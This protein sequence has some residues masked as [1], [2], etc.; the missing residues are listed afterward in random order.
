[1]KIQDLLKQAKP[2][3]KYAACEPS[4]GWYLYKNKPR[5][6]RATWIDDKSPM[7][8]VAL[9]D[10]ERIFYIEPFNGDWKDSLISR[11]ECGL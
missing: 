10:L 4:G 9:Y 7:S 8:S 1:M 6:G 5:C 11:E 2:C 3:W